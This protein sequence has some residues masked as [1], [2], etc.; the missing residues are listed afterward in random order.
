MIEIGNYTYN[1]VILKTKKEAKEILMKLK[2]IFN[3]YGFIRVADLYDLSDVNTNYKDIR[4][5]WTNIRNAKVLRVREGYTIKMPEI[6]KLQ[7]D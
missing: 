2:E 6:E 7:I 3:Q 4:Y 5:G 1:N